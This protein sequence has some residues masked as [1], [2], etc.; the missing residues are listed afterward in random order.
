MAD[1]N[2][3]SIGRS[4]PGNSSPSITDLLGKDG[5]LARALPRYERRDGQVK[6]ADAILRTLRQHGSLVAEAPT[7]SG[8][9]AAALAAL[10]I[11]I[12][13]ERNKKDRRPSVILTGTV[14]LQDQIAK[15]DA[16]EFV[17]L[18]D[19]PFTF[20]VLKGRKQYVCKHKFLEAVGSSGG[21]LRATVNRMEGWFKKTKTGVRSEGSFDDKTW[22]LFTATGLECSMAGCMY[23]PEGDQSCFYRKARERAMSCD[24]VIANYHVALAKGP[25]GVL[26]LLQF[27]HVIC[28]EAH[29]LPNVA[30]SAFGSSLSAMNIRQLATVLPDIMGLLSSSIVS[31]DVL[32]RDAEEVFGRLLM[33][34]KGGSQKVVRLT[35]ER[36]INGDKLADMLLGISQAIGMV[37]TSNDDIDSKTKITLRSVERTTKNYAETLIN[38]NML[39]Y[40]DSWVYWLET[41]QPKSTS[42]RPY[43]SIER[44]PFLVGHQ[45]RRVLYGMDG[46]DENVEISTRAGGVVLMSATLRTASGFSFIRQEVGAP[47]NTQEV[48]CRSPFVLAT[49]AALVVP[50]Y[51]P[52][53]PKYGADEAAEKDYLENLVASAA[54][55]ALAMSG[56]TLCL[57]TSWSVLNYAY[58]RMSKA[59][60]LK[61]FTVVKQGQGPTQRLVAKFARQ[62]IDILLG[63]ASLWQGVDVPG[64][65]LKGLFI[66]KIP[67][68][69]PQEPINAAMQESI[70]RRVGPRASFNLWSIPVA[71]MMLQQGMGRLIRTTKDSGVCVIADRR[72][73]EFG[74]G[75]RICRALP[76]FSRFNSIST[77][78]QVLPG[79]FC[80][81]GA[82]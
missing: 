49:Q 4:A 75:K 30:R 62:E 14:A 72:L 16:P 63:V 34:A 74:Y 43:V 81:N 79:V 55:L 6:L 70:D 48:V 82:T 66:H 73:T 5:R 22:F 59:R 25:G 23:G 24:L 2:D 35:E 32:Y 56:R 71:T 60:M 1:L 40:P 64:D 45:I 27:D 65:A 26:N 20:A 77:A 36:R 29:G 69:S 8:K 61:R 3:R 42:G 33:E 44:R 17:K 57:F 15:K 54:E 7:G 46:Q 80:A 76:K 12:N 37:L 53:T 13:E 67:F 41:H 10:S 39:E 47:D 31:P 19:D 28:D 38:A 11:I 21:R 9:S 58:E 50:D 52:I 78:R 18:L 68:P 51:V